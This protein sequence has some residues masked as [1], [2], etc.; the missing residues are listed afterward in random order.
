MAVLNEKIDECQ[1]EYEAQC[2]NLDIVC[3]NEISRLKDD[4]KQS[5]MDSANRMVEK[6]VGKIL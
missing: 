3:D 1:K 5:K 6:I 4:C 2:E